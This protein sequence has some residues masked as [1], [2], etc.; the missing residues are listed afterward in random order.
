LQDFTPAAT[1][2][3]RTAG[4][5]RTIMDAIRQKIQALDPSLPLTN[6]ATIDQQLDQAL[7]APRMGAALLGVFGFLALALAAFG[8]Y[9]VMAY[10]VTQRRQEIGIRVALG[11]SSRQVIGMVLKQGMIWAVLGLAIGI[12]VSAALSRL[13]SG[14]L[15][16][17]SATDPIVFASVSAILILVALAACYIP[18][19]RATRVDPLNA[20]RTE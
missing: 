6:I 19:L 8:V 10:A 15:F 17:V 4:D 11:A 7:W 20:L 1:I 16:G 18:A 14:L 9:G 2:Q 12:V 13:V 5:P 3:V